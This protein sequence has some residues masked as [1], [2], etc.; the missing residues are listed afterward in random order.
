MGSA[1]VGYRAGIRHDAHAFTVSRNAPA[2]IVL[3]VPGP[4]TRT[5]E[6]VL[7]ADEI[8]R[9]VGQTPPASQERRERPNGSGTR[10]C[11]VGEAPSSRSTTGRRYGNG[12]LPNTWSLPYVCPL[13]VE[14]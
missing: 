1:S 13:D 3:D 4:A 10:Q 14:K 9:A 11:D 5:V 2:S 8:W 6:P 7:R 12:A